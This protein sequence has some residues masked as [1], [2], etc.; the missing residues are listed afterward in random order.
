M[1][2]KWLASVLIFALFV[3]TAFAPIAYAGEESAE[4]AAAER[5]IDQQAANLDAVI[6]EE[7]RDLPHTPEAT[8]S[9]AAL[10]A[11]NHIAQSQAKAEVAKKNTGVLGYV[12]SLDSAAWLR[13]ALGGVKG[14]SRVASILASGGGLPAALVGFGIE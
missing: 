6:D 12:R 3:N 1:L 5:S 10:H 9:I 4:Q 13:L 14:V 8:A 2:R 11:Q 7:A